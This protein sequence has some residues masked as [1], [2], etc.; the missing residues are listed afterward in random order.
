MTVKFFYF[1]I[2]FFFVRSLFKHLGWVL[3]DVQGFFDSL[4]IFHRTVTLV[5]VHELFSFQFKGYFLPKS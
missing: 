3:I 1:C 2:V 5:N 4:I